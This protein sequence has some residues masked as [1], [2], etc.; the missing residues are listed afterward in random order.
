MVSTCI[1]EF[2]RQNV[3]Q[4]AVDVIY[5]D[6]WGGYRMLKRYMPHRMIHHRIT[7]VDGPIH[8]N[9]I[10]S[11]WSLLERGIVGVFHHISI[12]H[13]DRYLAEF[14]WRFDN[15][16]AEDILDAIMCNVERK[17]SGYAELI[18]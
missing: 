14:S 3:N 6:E 9:T 10:E 11:F 5:S 7:F 12:K 18:A 8:T 17:H 15:R 16:K 1:F 2:I 4:D 13:L